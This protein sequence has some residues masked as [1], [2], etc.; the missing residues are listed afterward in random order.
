[1]KKILFLFTLI[2]FCLNIPEMN[3]QTTSPTSSFLWVQQEETSSSTPSLST[4]TTTSNP[5]VP[6]TISPAELSP[7]P[8]LD[9]KTSSGQYDNQTNEP[10]YVQLLGISAIDD[11]IHLGS[12]DPRVIVVRLINAALGLLGIIFV[13]MIL[14]SGAL[15]LFSFGKDENITKA[16][17]S[18]FSAIIGLIIILS[19]YSIVQFILNAFGTENQSPEDPL[20]LDEE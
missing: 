11:L 2:I 1:M 16:K 10:F 19:A 12:A 5:S 6:P 9:E 15:L 8:T 14:Y 20:L 18:F 13:I 7:T 17:K 3:A 4:E